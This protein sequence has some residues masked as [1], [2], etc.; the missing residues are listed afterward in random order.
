DI[1]RLKATLGPQFEVVSRTLDDTQWIVAVD[2]P[3]RVVSSYLYERDSGK[4]TKLFDQR[5]ELKG[6]PLQPMKPLELRARDG[7][8]LVSYLTLPPGGNAGSGS[9]RDTPSGSAGA[10]EPASDARGPVDHRKADR[11]SYR[12]ARPVPMVLDVHGGP[13]ARD[14]FGFNAEHQWLAKP[15][16]AV[17]SLH[18]PGSTGLCQKIINS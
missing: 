6:A 11:A 18:Y 10:R 17:L 1:E 7:L 12:P 9:S 14:S 3:I 13:W 5:P 4:V 8:A 2:D 16:Y 15:G